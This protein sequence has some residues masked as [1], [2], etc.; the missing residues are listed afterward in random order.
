MKTD[1]FIHWHLDGRT[2]SVTQHPDFNETISKQDL[3]RFRQ[4]FV[5]QNRPTLVLIS[6]LPHGAVP[7]QPELCTTGLGLTARRLPTAAQG[8]YKSKREL[9]LSQ[10]QAHVTK[11]GLTL[12]PPADTARHTV[13]LC[14]TNLVATMV[15]LILR[16]APSQLP[17]QSEDLGE[18]NA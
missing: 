5:H 18:R 7:G 10:L 6:H 16:M 12:S 9:S 4:T 8:T 2:H 15:Q 11:L 14:A 13:K 3:D 1:V 17:V